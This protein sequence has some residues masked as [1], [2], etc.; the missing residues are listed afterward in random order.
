MSC[1][2]GPTCCYP[3]F[4][5]GSVSGL[6][7]CADYRNVFSPFL[8][9]RRIPCLGPVSPIFVVGTFR[10]NRDSYSYLDLTNANGSYTLPRRSCT[11]DGVSYST[12]PESS[13]YG[14]T[15][16]YAG[17]SFPGSEFCTTVQSALEIGLSRPTATP[18][19]LRGNVTLILPMLFGGIFVA[20]SVVEID[21][22]DTDGT[23]TSDRTK[24][25]CGTTISATNSL[26]YSWFPDS[27]TVSV[28]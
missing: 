20:S 27:I 18:N 21:C 14:R 5:T 24:F 23:V 9:D 11:T 6:Y 1:C 19:K 10:S 17:Y 4:L 25:C 7:G 12:L 22:L 15:C 26:T 2:C 3:E 16:N 28:S 13:I 8:P